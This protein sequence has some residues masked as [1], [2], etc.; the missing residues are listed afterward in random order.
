[1]TEAHANYCRIHTSPSNLRKAD[2]RKIVNQMNLKM[3][4]R[5][6]FPKI[7]VPTFIQRGQSL[8]ISYSVRNAG[9]GYCQVTCY[10][11]FLLKDFNGKEVTSVTDVGFDHQNLMSGSDNAT[12][13]RN[14]SLTIPVNTAAGNY[15]LFISMVDETG[16]P[17]IKLPYDGDDGNKQYKLTQV[18]IK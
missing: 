2:V 10:P 5:I 7:S 9:V 8:K 1:M 17:V 11:H 13:N 16:K 18:S 15:T 12:L 3:G 4:Y 14:V 6:Q